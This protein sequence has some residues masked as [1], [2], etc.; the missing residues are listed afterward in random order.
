[1]LVL[2]GQAVAQHY[3]NSNFVAYVV[4]IAHIQASAEV[5]DPNEFLSEKD[6]KT[7]KEEPA[8]EEEIDF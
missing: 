8:F 4:N 2:G 1:M 7:K 6:D 3:I 5:G